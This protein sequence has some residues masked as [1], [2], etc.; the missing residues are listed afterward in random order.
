MPTL[1]SESK[2]QL[3]LPHS[4]SLSSHSNRPPHSPHAESHLIVATPVVTQYISA[5]LTPRTTASSTSAAPNATSSA[6]AS[7]LLSSSTSNLSFGSSATLTSSPPSSVSSGVSQP[8]ITSVINSQYVSNVDTLSRCVLFANSDNPRL[9]VAHKVNK[10]HTDAY[11]DALM[12]AM[13]EA[14]VE[15]QRQRDQMSAVVRSE[16]DGELNPFEQDSDGLTASTRF[17]TRD[18][19]AAPQHFTSQHTHS[20]IA[21]EAARNRNSSSDVDIDNDTFPASPTHP[22]SVRVP[23]PQSS[24]TSQLGSTNSPQPSPT[25]SRQATFGPTPTPSLQNVHPLA[26]AA[27]LHVDPTASPR[28]NKSQQHTANEHDSKHRM[29]TDK[30][31]EK[32]KLSGGGLIETNVAPLPHRPGMDDEWT[33]GEQ[34]SL[35]EQI[36]LMYVEIYWQNP[37]AFAPFYRRRMNTW[38]DKATLVYEHLMQSRHKESVINRWRRQWHTRHIRKRMLDFFEQELIRLDQQSA[39]PSH[40]Q[41]HRNHRQSVV[42]QRQ[43]RAAST[44]RSFPNPFRATTQQRSASRR[45]LVELQEGP[46]RPSLRRQ[47]TQAELS[48]PLTAKD[49]TTIPPPTDAYFSRLNEV[50]SALHA[51]YVEVSEVVG[52][53]IVERLLTPTLPESIVDAAALNREVVSTMHSTNVLPLLLSYHPEYQNAALGF[54]GLILMSRTLR[55]QLE[56]PSLEFEQLQLTDLIVA[57]NDLTETLRTAFHKLVARQPA[58]LEQ[59][60]QQKRFRVL[61]KVRQAEEEEVQRERERGKEPYPGS[62]SFWLYD[63]QLYPRRFNNE[64]LNVLR[65]VNRQDSRVFYLVA[66]HRFEQAAKRLRQLND[67]SK[68]LWLDMLV[69]RRKQ[70]SRDTMIGISSTTS[71]QSRLKQQESSD[72]LRS[73]TDKVSAARSPATN[74]LPSPHDALLSPSSGGEEMEAA[75]R[76][77][78][79][80]LMSDEYEDITAGRPEHYGAKVVGMASH[81]T[82]GHIHKW[83]DI[84]AQYVVGLGRN[85]QTGELEPWAVYDKTFNEPLFHDLWTTLKVG[86]MTR[87][88]IHNHQLTLKR[89][90]KADTVQLFLSNVL[91]CSNA[92]TSQSINVSAE[93]FDDPLLIWKE[94]KRPVDI[95]HPT[96]PI[97]F[98]DF[99]WL[100]MFISHP[101]LQPL[102]TCVADLNDLVN[103]RSVKRRPLH[104]C[105][106]QLQEDGS[107]RL[108]LNRSK[109]IQ[110]VKVI[111]LKFPMSSF[112]PAITRAVFTN[113]IKGG[114]SGIPF[115]G[116]TQ[117]MSALLERVF[118]FTDIL[119]LQRHSQAQQSV[120]EALDG[121]D[122]S[123]FSHPV[124][125]TAMLET[126][127]FYLL[128]TNIMLSGVIVNS[129]SANAT[130]AANYIK[131]V[132]FKR[133]QAIEMLELRG[134]TVIP[135]P[136]SYYAVSYMRDPTTG[137]LTKLKLHS[138]GFRKIARSKKPHAAVD[139]FRPHRERRKR[140]V[141]QYL[142]TM[143]NFFYVPLPAVGGVCKMIYKEVF[144]REIHKRQMWEAGLLGHIEHNPGQLSGIL[145][146]ELRMDQHFAD[147][148]E[149][150]CI[151]IL[152][153]R[154]LSPFDLSQEEKEN[155]RA[156]VETWI[157]QHDPDYTSLHPPR[158]KLTE[159]KTHD[160]RS[161]DRT[162]A[163][164]QPPEPK[165]SKRSVSKAALME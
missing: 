157:R 52:N 59:L 48:A 47:L 107:Y 155:H 46:G 42:R 87:E 154:R 33:M 14:S 110:P 135:L 2:E 21:E 156:I 57:V 83:V 91:F 113:A 147:H 74:P 31:G 114:L 19:S 85:E 97:A 165:L 93:F 111:D 5:A 159:S 139:L 12:S 127:T 36:L 89:M 67:D 41:H 16:L 45:S 63:S 65:H 4:S 118:D 90:K 8:P 35:A 146:S 62:F 9:I 121:S 133:Q 80:E 27:H 24:S 158:V 151:L 120:L 150:Q 79:D 50:C 138:L 25:S 94:G 162:P 126:A 134:F 3:S 122:T 112:Q 61:R 148:V 102:I 140:L 26:A 144:V 103:P 69:Q 60:V 1:A 39:D 29:D 132:D 163:A 84:S 64:S 38:R 96:R 95:H 109:T 92:T 6:S 143:A 116:P 51:R 86:F 32:A 37:K 58:L 161:P 20:P 77:G 123:P 34:I 104:H 53:E 23:L 142:L 55:R 131:K 56:N 149:A 30:D 40:P 18:S 11:D 115:Y 136:N 141:L 164:D 160:I 106:F 43:D 125:T 70:E 22:S 7:P 100:Q 88:N 81:T 130:L 10:A 68:A 153:E 66:A 28:Y 124:F 98:D 72:S 75:A 105:Y 73:L 15:Q 101:E 76:D 129:V 78:R 17:H 145:Q 44:A 13:R 49:Q 128:R 117:T 54:P 82:Y 99:E 108:P 71:A 152:E 119:Y 137:Q